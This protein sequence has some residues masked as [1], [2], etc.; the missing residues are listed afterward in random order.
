MQ[1]FIKKE[2]NNKINKLVDK[3]D[4][5]LLI[6]KKKK[7]IIPVIEIVIDALSILLN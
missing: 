3:Y 7:Y 2:E 4:K 6:V 5:K 1:K